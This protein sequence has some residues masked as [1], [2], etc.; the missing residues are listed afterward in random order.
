M[1]YRESSEVYLMNKEDVTVRLE[2]EKDYRTVEK[3]TIDAF[4]YR[5]RIERGQIVCPY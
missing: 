1:L 3:I 2:E 5:D 4:N